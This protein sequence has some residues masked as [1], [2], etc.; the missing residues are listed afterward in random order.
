MSQLLPAPLFTQENLPEAFKPHAKYNQQAEDFEKINKYTWEK[1]WQPCGE[2]RKNKIQEATL[3]G[4]E[5]YPLESFGSYFF[6]FKPDIS[7]KF[8]EDLA[9]ASS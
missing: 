2:M 5:Y 1:S 8:F 9:F 3:R 4:K 7:D 6:T